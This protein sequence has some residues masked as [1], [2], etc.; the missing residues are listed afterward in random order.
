[1]GY[2]KQHAPIAPSWAVDV[3]NKPREW[4][5]PNVF[6]KGEL[7]SLQG[8]PGDGKIWP[9]CELAAQTS[10]GGL[11]Q[12]VRDENDTA[13]LPCGNVMY[14]PATTRWRA[15]CRKSARKKMFL[16]LIL[17]NSI[18]LACAPTHALSSKSCNLQATVS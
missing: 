7:N 1:M 11:V 18:F 2:N 12:G 14:R 13:E 6:V 3:P 9:M 15:V 4:F 10:I 17:P 5:Y 8:I 16:N